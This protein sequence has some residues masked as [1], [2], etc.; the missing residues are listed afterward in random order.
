MLFNLYSIK[1]I[2]ACEYAPP[3]VSKNDEVAIRQVRQS[4]AKLDKSVVMDFELHRIGQWDD[5]SGKIVVAY[6]NTVKVEG[7]FRSVEQLG[8][9]RDQQR[10]PLKKKK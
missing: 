10:L 7:D 6:E 4:Y 9:E 2:V 8:Q 5:E 3:F 1:D